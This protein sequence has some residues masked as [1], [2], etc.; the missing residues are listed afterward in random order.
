MTSNYHTDIPVR[1]NADASIFN[2]PLGQLDSAITNIL[3]GNSAYPFTRSLINTTGA[4]TIAGGQL[5]VANIS[6]ITI[7]SETGVT[8]DLDTLLNPAVGVT[9][10]LQAAAG[11]TITV[12]HNTGN[13]YLNAA[14]D[15]TLTGNSL[16]ALFYSPLGKA[17]DLYV[18]YVVP[19]QA[20]VV[21]TGRTVVGASVASVTISSIPQT[22]KHLLLILELR[23]SV[24]ATL[25][26]VLVRF[27]ADAT[28]ANYYTQQMFAAAAAATA[29]ESL[30]AS[31]GLLI[32]N[33]AVG[34][35]GNAGNAR[36]MMWITDYASTTS[37]R[38]AS[39]QA[40]THAANTTTNLKYSQGGGI[41][42]N[43]VNG[44]SSITFLCGTGPNILA[45]SAYE[46]IGLN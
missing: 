12:K 29:S 13:I 34:S 14:T 43:A 9:Y 16:L 45:N 33:G 15:V 7:T 40:L 8:D 10:I 21:H 30:A 26:N 2:A 20:A 22:Y 44:I 28:A 32:T 1:S 39:W 18:P 31:T 42:T 36:I 41:W 38:G 6:F 24:A 46:L 17:T 25:D 35:T 23:S 27:N 3:A 19:T 5:D 11:H 37:R 4:G